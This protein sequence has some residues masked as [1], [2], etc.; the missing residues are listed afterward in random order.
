MGKVYSILLGFCA[1]VLAGTA[2]AQTC[3]NAPSAGPCTGANVTKAFTS[4]AGGFSGGGF[5]WNSGGGY[6]NANV[7][8]NNSYTLTSE[9]YNLSATGGNVGFT[10]AGSTASL[11]NVTVRIVDASTSAVLFTC[12]QT[13][14]NFVA[15]NQVCVQYSG[16]TPGTNVRFEFIFNT[17]NGAPGDGVVRFDNFA[18]GAAAAAVPVKLDNLDAASA[19]NGIKLTWIASD[20]L[21]LSSFEIERSPNGANFQLIGSVKAENKK[22]YSFTDNFPSSANNFYRLKMVDLDGKYRISHIVSV[23]GKATLGIE[24]FP[25]PVKDRAVVQHPKAKAST[26]IQI[27]N[28]QGQIVKTVDV[29]VNAVATQ[30]EMS[31]LKNGAY[32]LIFRSATENFSQRIVKQ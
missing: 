22:S 16:I 4:S 12:T 13:P 25:N 1:L 11:N 32:Y 6:L 9:I 21:G 2:N 23:K 7:A 29:P 31:T 3:T 24:T 27:V 8:K 5:T 17:V 10:I 15:A 19:G 26:F 28:L 18:G 30:V 14:A 20:E